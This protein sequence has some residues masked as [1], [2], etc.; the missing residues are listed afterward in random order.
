MAFNNDDMNNYWDCSNNFLKAMNQIAALSSNIQIHA[1]FI[2]KTKSEV[3]QLAMK[4]NVDL[5]QTISCYQ[6]QNA[7]YFTPD[8]DWNH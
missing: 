3:V 5:S 4:L 6:P 2:T 7:M 8:G 1:P